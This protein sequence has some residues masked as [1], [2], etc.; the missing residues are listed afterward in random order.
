MIS[1]ISLMFK[2]LAAHITNFLTVLAC[3]VI[4]QNTNTL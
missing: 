3:F 4:S 2:G 1:N